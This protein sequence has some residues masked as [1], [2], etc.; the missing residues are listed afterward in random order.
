M[1]L[2]SQDTELSAESQLQGEVSVGLFSDLTFSPSTC[3]LANISSLIQPT[4]YWKA[5][6]KTSESLCLVICNSCYKIIFR[7]INRESFFSGARGPRLGI[8]WRFLLLKSSLFHGSV[9]SNESD[10]MEAQARCPGRLRGL[11]P[12][13]CSEAAWMWCWAASGCPCSSRGL[14]QV[15]SGGPCQPQAL[16]DYVL[17]MA[18]PKTWGLHPSSPSLH[19][20]F[21]AQGKCR[22][23]VTPG[24][25]CFNSSTGTVGIASSSVLGFLWFLCGNS[26]Q[27]SQSI[28]SNALVWE[29]PFVSE[30]WLW[31]GLMREVF[32]KSL[33]NPPV[34]LSLTSRNNSP[35][36]DPRSL[37]YFISYVTQWL[38]S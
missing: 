23:S 10:Q 28:F 31:A 21:G 18:T 16:C 13:R 8:L 30:E 29:K 9:G 6:N 5:R 24:F 4:V 32:F 34:S 25:Y 33:S 27:W 2:H 11:P 20:G 12:W 15:A 35:H 22:D 17:A 14:G 38:D 37:L 7:K 26:W 1:F 3:L 19:V 36:L